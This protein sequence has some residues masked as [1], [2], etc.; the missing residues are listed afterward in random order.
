M[1]KKLSPMTFMRERRL[2]PPHTQNLLNSVK[3]TAELQKEPNESFEMA[4]HRIMNFS[5]FNE[6][7]LVEAI[8]NVREPILT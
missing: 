2:R 7:L 5:Q 4:V 8:N 1:V 3:A 6:H